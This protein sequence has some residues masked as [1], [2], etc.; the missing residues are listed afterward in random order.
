M[1]FPYR[2][3]TLFKHTP[4]ANWVIIGLT[5]LGFFL[6]TGGIFSDDAISAMVLDGWGLT[7]LIGHV[8]LHVG[9]LHLAGNML[10][11][12]VFGNAVCGNTSNTLYPVAYLGFALAAA[13]AHLLFDGDPAVGASGAVNGVVGMALA[14]YPLNR[15]RVLWWFWIKAGSFE[16]PLWGLALTWLGFDMFGALRGGG[17]VAYWAR[18]GGFFAGVGVGFLALRQGWVTLTRYDHSSLEEI[19]TGKNAEQRQERLRAEEAEADGEASRMYATLDPLVMTVTARQVARWTA[20]AQAQAVS[21]ADAAVIEGG[22]DA[23]ERKNF[24]LLYGRSFT[25]LGFSFHRSMADYYRKV[26]EGKLWPH[27]TH[28]LANLL[29]MVEEDF[30]AMQRVGFVNA[31]LVALRDEERLAAFFRNV[32][33]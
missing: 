12:W 23:G 17:S 21:P 15:V 26:A 14:M 3:D 1:L 33:G 10:F 31:E 13:G 28:A 20:A 32:G 16:A 27:E 11:L 8:L 2:I 5:V 19:F 7:G 30:A 4:Y 25:G 6:L 29:R 9:F 22:G 24:E 18:L